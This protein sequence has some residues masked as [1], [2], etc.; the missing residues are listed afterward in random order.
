MSESKD[1]PKVIA[2]PTVRES[3][4]VHGATELSPRSAYS[5]GSEWSAT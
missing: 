5:G 3:S 2:L 4:G 1:S